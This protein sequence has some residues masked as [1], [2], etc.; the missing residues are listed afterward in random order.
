LNKYYSPTTSAHEA[1]SMNVPTPKKKISY[2]IKS[3]NPTIVVI[4]A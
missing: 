1:F 3:S 4:H 2:S